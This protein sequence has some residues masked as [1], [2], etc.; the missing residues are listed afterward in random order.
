MEQ[1][2]STREAAK[3]KPMGNLLQ[4]MDP[5]EET[6]TTQ[7]PSHSLTHI[8]PY[9]QCSKNTNNEAIHDLHKHPPILQLAH[10][11][12]MTSRTCRINTILHIQPRLIIR[13]VLSRTRDHADIRTLLIRGRLSLFHALLALG[14]IANAD[15][16]L[17]S[18]VARSLAWE[19]GF[20][21]R[22]WN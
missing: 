2:R 7:S 6:R 17:L 15:G 5:R 19:F 21:V 22:N 9:C 3:S 20:G 13:M 18:W 4:L 8:P 11:L 14:H 12:T 1:F 16:K 10:P